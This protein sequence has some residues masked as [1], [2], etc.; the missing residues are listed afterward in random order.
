[1]NIL[2]K[3]ICSA[4]ACLLLVLSLGSCSMDF[5]IVAWEDGIIPYYLSGN[6]TDEEVDVIHE[7][8]AEWE[9]VCGVIFEESKPSSA[10]YCIERTSQ[11][12]WSSSVGENNYECRMYFGRGMPPVGT[13]VHEL[14]HCLG[15]LHE[16]QRPDRDEYVTVFWNNILTGKEFNFEKQDNPLINEEDYDYDFES[17]MHYP[18]SSFSKNGRDTIM[19]NHGE[20]IRRHTEHPYVT[21]TDIAK[22]RAIYGEPAER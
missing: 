17:I 10:A 3:T 12:V 8:M 22:V 6:F 15:L 16:H 18:T 4:A 5:P 19:S 14:G 21:D 20:T 11:S 9:G 1:M 2:N 7:A 13:V